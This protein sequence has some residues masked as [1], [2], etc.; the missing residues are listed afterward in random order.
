[1]FPFLICI[2][3]IYSSDFLEPTGIIESILSVIYSGP[4]WP[5]CKEDIYLKKYVRKGMDLVKQGGVPASKSLH[6][7]Y[8]YTTEYLLSLKST[9]ISTGSTTTA[10]P[11]QNPERVSD[12]TGGDPR[13]LGQRPASRVSSG[14][15]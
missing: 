8:H 13:R 11:L 9:G 6:E 4:N 5:N 15:W 3:Q 14:S 1:M 2:V 7:S 10:C 12:G